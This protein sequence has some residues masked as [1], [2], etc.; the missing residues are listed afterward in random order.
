MSHDPTLMDR[1]FERL[2][3][4]LALRSTRRSLFGRA[5]AVVLGALGFELVPLLP[6]DRRAYG[7]PGTRCNQGQ[8]C[9]I[10]GVPCA[11]PA[12]RIGMGKPGSDT[13][14]PQFTVQSPGKWCGCCFCTDPVVGQGFAVEYYDC[15]RDL[16]EPCGGQFCPNAPHGDYCADTGLNQNYYC[17]LA[18]QLNLPCGAP[19]GPGNYDCIY[20]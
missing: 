20:F 9:N 7:D 14:C 2:S 11:D 10:Y 3:R 8:Y 6:V 4:G 16:D 1:V 13:T 15:C 12:C 5:A 18:I 17:T 19:C